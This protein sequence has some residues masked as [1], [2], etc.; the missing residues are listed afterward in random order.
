MGYVLRWFTKYAI[1][2]HLCSLGWHD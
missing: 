2:D 1:P